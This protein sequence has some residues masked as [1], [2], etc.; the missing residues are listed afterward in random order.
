MKLR[1]RALLAVL[2]LAAGAA[3]A[4]GVARSTGTGPIPDA[5]GVIHACYK[6]PIGEA[7]IVYS[8]ANC[9]SGQV[10][11]QWSQAGGGQGPKGDPGPQGP[12]GETGPQGPVGP[13]GTGGGNV[14]VFQSDPLPRTLI[15]EIGG[16]GQAGTF[17]VVP[18]PGTYWITAKGTLSV[19][20]TIAVEK[21]GV[22]GCTL[23]MG[24]NV[25][26]TT[27][28]LTLGPTIG[29]RDAFPFTVSAVVQITQPDQFVHALC[30]QTGGPPDRLDVAIEN[31]RITALKVS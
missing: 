6:K 1:Y 20:N 7:K 14:K 8:A 26:D 25:F 24:A 19:Q 2:V 29:T 17:M 27:S 16:Q 15:G 18:E 9:T 3:I 23:E 11:I 31:L 5:Q 4:A 28:N 13:P 12:Q 10:P 21:I 30:T 22:G